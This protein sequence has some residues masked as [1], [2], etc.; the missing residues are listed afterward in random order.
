MASALSPNRRFLAFDVRRADIGG[1]SKFDFFTVS[2]RMDG[3]LDEDDAPAEPKW[4][5]YAFRAA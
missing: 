5:R 3:S 1:V 2:R 4:W